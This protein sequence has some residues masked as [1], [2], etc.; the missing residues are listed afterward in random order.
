MRSQSLG[1]APRAEGP[2]HAFTSGAILCTVANSKLWVIDLRQ[3]E[4][5]GNLKKAE[6][7]YVEAISGR[8]CGVSVLCCLVCFDR[9]FDLGSRR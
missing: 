5:K 3:Y 8:A 4:M 6:H 7:Y 9:C 1:L 2:I